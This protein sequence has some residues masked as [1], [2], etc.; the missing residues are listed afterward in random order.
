MKR[1]I[2]VRFFVNLLIVLSLLSPT[3]LYAFADGKKHFKDGMNHEVP[4][5][6]DR[7]SKIFEI[8]LSLKIRRT[9][10]LGFI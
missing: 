7:L 1:P 8:S 6:W 3:A 4:E 10:N 9:R 2:H 5:E